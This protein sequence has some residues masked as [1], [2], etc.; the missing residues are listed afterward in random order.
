VVRQSEEEGEGEGAAL[1]Q[2]EAVTQHVGGRDDGGGRSQVVGRD[3]SPRA[4]RD[5]AV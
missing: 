5:E 2:M 1:L 3:R 4:A